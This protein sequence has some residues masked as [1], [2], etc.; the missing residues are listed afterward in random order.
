MARQPIESTRSR[1][2]NYL[3]VVMGRRPMEV[4]FFN[5]AQPEE[6]ER[7]LDAARAKRTELRSMHPAEAH[8]VRLVAWRRPSCGVA[9][10]GVQF[11][12][13]VFGEVN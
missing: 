9:L 10:D 8:T 12:G 11:V 13:F 6:I 1:V 5:D 4:H 7:V 3:Q 2:N